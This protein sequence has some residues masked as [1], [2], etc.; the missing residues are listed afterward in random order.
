MSEPGDQLFA[1]QFGEI[2]VNLVDLLAE[3]DGSSRE[4]VL[5]VLFG[6]WWLDRVARP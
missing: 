1:Q 4:Q 6:D 5:E 2:I 3:L